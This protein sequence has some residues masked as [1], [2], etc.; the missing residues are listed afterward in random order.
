MKRSLDPP[1]ARPASPLARRGGRGVFL[2]EIAGDLAV[3]EADARR[4]PALRIPFST[5]VRFTC[6]TFAGGK[7][8]NQ[9][10]EA[11]L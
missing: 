9:V 5:A 8:L 1:A 7:P 3:D 10:E 11:W 4:Y 6:T 2:R